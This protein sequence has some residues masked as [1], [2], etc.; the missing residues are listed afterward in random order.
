MPAVIDTGGPRV[1]HNNQTHPTTSFISSKFTPEKN[2]YYH[3]YVDDGPQHH[4]RCYHEPQH[5]DCHHNDY[6]YHDCQHN[7]YYYHDR[8][9]NDYYYHDRQHNDYHYH[10][11]Q[12]Y[13]YQ[14]RDRQQHDYQ[15]HHYHQEQFFHQQRFKE[16]SCA[17]QDHQHHQE[18]FVLGTKL[19]QKFKKN[20]QRTNSGGS[21]HQ[22]HQEFLLGTQFF[23][24]PKFEQKRKRTCS[25]SLLDHHYH[26]E[27]FLP[28][29]QL[30]QNQKFE[31]KRGGQEQFLLVSQLFKNQKFKNKRERTSSGGQEQFVLRTKLFQNQKFEPKLKRTCSEGLLDHQEH[32]EFL[33]HTQFFKNPKFDP[34]CSEGLQDHQEQLFLGTQ[35]SQNQ[36]FESKRECL[37]D[38]DDSAPEVRRRARVK[39]PR[40]SD[41]TSA[42]HDIEENEGRNQPELRGGSF[43]IA[44]QLSSSL[45]SS[46][47]C[48]V[49]ASRRY[50]E[51]RGKLNIGECF[52][53]KLK[54]IK[55]KSDESF[56]PGITFKKKS[57]ISS[58]HH[59]SRSF[60]HHPLILN[61]NCDYTREAKFPPINFNF[62]SVINDF[63]VVSSRLDILPQVKV[64]PQ[65][66]IGPQLK[67]GPKSKIGSK[68]GPELKSGPKSKIGPQLNIERRK[69]AIDKS[70]Q[71]EIYSKL[72]IDELTLDEI[73]S[74]LGI[75]ELNRD[76]EQVKI[77]SLIE[78]RLQERLVT[79][80]EIT[81]KSLSSS[82]SSV[83]RKREKNTRQCT[84]NCSYFQL[85]F[86]LFLIA[87]GQSGL[88]SS[89]GVL[90]FQRNKSTGLSVFTIG[91]VIGAVRA[92]PIDIL[93]DTGIRA[94]RSANLSHITGASRKIQ[95]YVKNR[96]L[97]ILPNGTVNGSNDDTSDYTIFQRM[98][99]SRGQLRIQGVATCLYLCMDSC[100]L[101]YGSHEYTEDCI[102]NETIE[103]HNYNTY[104]SVRWSTNQ[105]TL[106]LGL[107]RYGEPRRVQAKGH[108][109][110]RLS[111]Y[112]RVLT[113]VVS[114]DRVET[115][116]RRM[117][118]T[119]HNVRHR[120]NAHHQHK[121]QNLCPRILQPEKD[122]VDN[123]R[124]RKRKKR[125]KRKRKCRE[126]ESPGPQCEH[127]V[128]S[129]NSSEGLPESKRS[130]E[131]AASDEVCRRQAMDAA[132]KKRKSRMEKPSSKQQHHHH[133]QH[134]QQ[135]QKESKKGQE[136]T[137][138]QNNNNNNGA[139]GATIDIALFL[140]TWFLN[141]RI[142]CRSSFC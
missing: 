66:E 21:N 107:N 10:D 130:C 34:K 134:Q 32:Q 14:Y 15:C 112:S 120:H 80:D 58:H 33:L 53:D 2:Y 72:G 30:F 4:D 86:L 40:R 74:K 1:L 141:H 18:Q 89:S 28:G 98:S 12:H 140:V 97:Q 56:D 42:N 59:R 70:N 29:S 99:V 122:N 50:T 129:A 83:R 46:T 106:Y 19:F 47:T 61:N 116:H 8:Q 102:F 92:A 78:S 103:Q 118:A 31:N 5:H 121:Q 16:K 88:L 125:R 77:D 95:M 44:N 63:N 115:L 138:G 75:D 24:N 65:L 7:D 69:L 60:N 113:M 23:K 62:D 11:C 85:A 127:H 3:D 136:E 90:K 41:F 128:D 104:S 57:P 48:H 35:F 94:E 17:L 55:F 76:Y 114:P 123:Y 27:E 117:F 38:P 51:C 87:F 22:H 108:N 37:P 84:K 39:K 137:S 79:R 91:M 132:S 139:K 13:D 133:H 119:H 135:Q 111:A 124:C 67:I 45:S 64:V 105:K 81:S 54:G 36:K 71:V 82:L 96:Y 6:H 52:F 49:I 9:H 110:G 142:I 20:R 126:D 101:L 109:L 25:E 73:D 43:E 68:I 131:G 26:Q 100:G 93:S